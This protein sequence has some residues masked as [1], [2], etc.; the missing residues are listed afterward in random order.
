MPG[1]QVKLQR[2]IGDAL[3][4]PALH[5]DGDDV[6]GGDLAALAIALVDEDAVLADADRAMPVEVDDVRLFEHADAIGELLLQLI[7]ARA[8]VDEFEVRPAP[9]SCSLE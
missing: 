2:R 9:W 8:L 4:Q 3:D 6:G 5:V 1:V 7:H